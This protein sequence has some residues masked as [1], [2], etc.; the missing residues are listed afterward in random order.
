MIAGAGARD[1]T[2]GASEF[3]D[4]LASCGPL[5]GRRNSAKIEAHLDKHGYGVC[6]RE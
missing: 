6:S 3:L 5:E 4:D 1:V 2:G